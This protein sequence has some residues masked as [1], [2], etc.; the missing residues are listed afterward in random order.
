[1]NGVKRRERLTQYL[2]M[3]NFHRMPTEMIDK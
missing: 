1:M 2:K 3:Y